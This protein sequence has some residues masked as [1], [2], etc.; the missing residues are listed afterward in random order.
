MCK[1]TK[2]YVMENLSSSIEELKNIRDLKS[3]LSKREEEISL[4]LISDISYMSN[5]YK[6]FME[7]VND[8]DKVSLRKKFL[9]IALRLFAPSALI[10]TKLPKGL[11]VELA[12]LFPDISPSVISNNISDL[13]F[14]YQRYKAFRNDIDRI[15]SEIKSMY[16]SKIPIND[17]D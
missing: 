7:I 15:Y 9:F 13:L 14:L 3:K 10:G 6:Y 1:F 16:L 11:R 5:I 12:K 2:N 4:P 17:A 8:T